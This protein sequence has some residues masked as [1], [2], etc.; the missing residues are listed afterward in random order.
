MFP[1]NEA[2]RKR[3]GLVRGRCL[4]LYTTLGF[5]T[6]ASYGEQAIATYSDTAARRSYCT[7]LVC[8][9]RQPLSRHVREV[10]VRFEECG[11]TN[12]RNLN[13]SEP[14]TRGAAIREP[15]N[16]AVVPNLLAGKAESKQANNIQSTRVARFLRN[17]LRWVS[18]RIWREDRRH[19]S[20]GYH[21]S[22][23]AHSK[24]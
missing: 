13:S 2:D 17:T 18:D 10:Q 11:W 16:T 8:E 20:S 5:P 14:E 19:G 4:T 7:H 9:A 21:F 6:S 23:F 24:G 3:K 1:R 22:S 12:V 15:P